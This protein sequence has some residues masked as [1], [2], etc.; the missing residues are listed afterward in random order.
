MLREEINSFKFC[1]NKV[2]NVTIIAGKFNKFPNILNIGQ[3]FKTSTIED[4]LWC[5][6][7]SALFSKGYNERMFS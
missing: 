3:S 1:S 5:Y 7:Y 2:L 4:E 6:V